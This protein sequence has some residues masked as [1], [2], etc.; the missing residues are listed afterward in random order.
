[1][2]AWINKNVDYKV[3]WKGFLDKL[4]DVATKNKARRSIDVNKDV[5]SLA[6]KTL[7]THR[8]DCKSNDIKSHSR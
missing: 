4:T 3:R 1:M 6:R 5:L 2:E 8:Y 7:K